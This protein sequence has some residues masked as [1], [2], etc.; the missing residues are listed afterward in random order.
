MINFS[1]KEPVTEQKTRKC[2]ECGNGIDFINLDVFRK[3]Y[4]RFYLIEL[5][6][7]YVD[8]LCRWTYE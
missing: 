3:L 8:L 5:L 2:A 1:K 7:S 4:C 6:Y